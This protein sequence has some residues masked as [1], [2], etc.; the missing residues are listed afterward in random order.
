MCCPIP[1]LAIFTISRLNILVCLDIMCCLI[2]TNARQN[3][4]YN[5]YVC[6]QKISW[7]FDIYQPCIGIEFGLYEP[8]T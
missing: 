6:F 1:T 3:L 4:C 2:L 7:H 5:D 8:P